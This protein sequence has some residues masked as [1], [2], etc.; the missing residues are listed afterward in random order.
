MN[1]CDEILTM[2]KFVSELNTTEWEVETPFGWQSFSGIGKTIEFQ[3]YVITTKTGKTLI[4]ADDHILL[5][6]YNLQDVD[7]KFCLLPS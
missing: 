5:P 6:M 7:S 1:K 4:C 2:D 3:E